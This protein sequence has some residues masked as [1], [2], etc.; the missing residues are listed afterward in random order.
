MHRTQARDLTHRRELNPRILQ[1][2][3]D[4]KEFCELKPGLIGWLMLNMGLA[5][6][7]SPHPL[8]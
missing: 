8:I 5:S 6:S 2:S 4:L 3:F 7:Q 1:G